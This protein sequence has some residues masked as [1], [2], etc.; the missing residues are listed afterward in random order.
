LA[1]RLARIV[2]D[3][4]EPRQAF[5]QKPCEELDARRVP[6]IEAVNLQAGAERRI[7]GFLRIPLHRIDREARGRHHV[8]ARPQ[9]LERG[10]ESDLHA[11]ARDQREASAQVG[12]LLALGVVEIAA[13]AAHRVVIA[14]H[15]HERPLAH[16][17]GAALAELRAIVRRFRLGRREPQRRV[18]RGSALNAQSGLLDDAAVVRFRRFAVG[19]PKRL[20]HPHEILPFGFRDES[21]EHD[22]LAP[23]LLRQ[24]REVRAIGLDGTQYA[25]AGTHLV[26][27]QFRVRIG[28]RFHGGIVFVARVRSATIAPAPLPW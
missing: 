20:R 24:T 23:L 5:R 11:S 26:L 27:G 19:A 10:L 15:R 1:D 25:Q 6:L 17:A 7:V 14:M 21:G 13:F 28:E 22:E 12:R 16:I 3:V 9:E 4:V 2:E 8:R 18:G